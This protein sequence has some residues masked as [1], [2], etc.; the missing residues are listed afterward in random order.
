MD[1]VFVAVCG[2]D[3]ARGVTLIEPEGSSTF[4]RHDRPGQTGDRPCRLQQARRSE[5]SGC[6]VPPIT[7]SNASDAAI[8][9]F[10]ERGVQAVAYTAAKMETSRRALTKYHV[11]QKNR[12]R[13]TD[14]SLAEGQ[15]ASRQGRVG[16]HLIRIQGC[17]IRRHERFVTHP[18]YRPK[19]S[20]SIPR[21]SPHDRLR[22]STT[23]CSAV[24]SKMQRSS[25]LLA[26]RNRR[27]P[28]EVMAGL[29]IGSDRSARHEREAWRNAPQ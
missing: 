20:Q 26:L 21:I 17:S 7:D 15:A 4:P 25:K 9:P 2:I 16:I 27:I 12:C 29:A 8:G 1:R 28:R 23:T 11:D 5:P 22:A 18:T 13:P 3:A 14:A 24:V 6:S 19:E 10:E